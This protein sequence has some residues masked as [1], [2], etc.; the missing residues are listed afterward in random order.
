MPYSYIN[1]GT[2]KT[3]LASRLYDSDNKFWDSTELGVY[4][5]RAL[6]T[7]NS[8]TSYWRKEFV[9]D[10]IAS[11]VWYDITNLTTA[12][13]TIRPLTITDQDLINEIQYYLLEPVS[14]AYPLTWTGSNQFTLTQIM[15]AIQR[16]RDEILSVT[17]CYITRTV[18][19][20]V[21]GRTFLSDT[22]IDV[23]RVAWLPVSGFG[24]SNIP[25]WPD[26]EWGL[27][28]FE[29][30]FTTKAPGT[31]SSYRQST[32]PPLSYDVDIPPAVPGDYEVLTVDAGGALTTASSSTFTI[33]D[34]Y[35]WV[36]VFGV[37]ADL[38]S[39]DSNA[40]DSMRSQYCQ[41]RYKQGVAALMN[42]S[43][44]LYAR[45][46]NIP[47]LI[48]P[49]QD[50]DNFRPRWQSETASDPETLALAGLNLMAAVPTPDAIYSLTLGVVQNAPT[51][52]NDGDN[53][54]LGRDE[55]EAVLD[56]C[57]HLASI[58]MGGAEFMATIPLLDRFHAVAAVYN[59]KLN[60]LGE[61]TKPMYEL[62]QGQAQRNPVLDVKV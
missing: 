9:M 48:E 45:V 7:W 11:T 22:V 10:T 13:N 46:N 55:L 62:S 1:F 30:D 20:A 36:I 28:S 59:S 18:V 43:A 29:Y 58:K 40:R 6:R 38:F 3:Q 56:Y 47:L 51:L 53:V 54:Q 19:P 8:L 16:V 25:L 31:P 15:D 50:T 4:I 23:R 14:S 26:D 60:Q 17:G 21:A 44:L 2:A 34:D 35:T 41:A 61:F 5:N 24:F 27:E 42:A 49:V 52:V 57:Q 33:P 39:R 37:L 32:Q 12:P